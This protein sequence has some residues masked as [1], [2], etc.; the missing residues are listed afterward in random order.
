MGTFAESYQEFYEKVKLRTL[1]CLHLIPDDI[2]QQRLREFR[3]V[4]SHKWNEGPIVEP[5]ALMVFQKVL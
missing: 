3:E 4:C 2:F 5:V 1:S